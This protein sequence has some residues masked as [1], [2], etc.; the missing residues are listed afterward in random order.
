MKERYRIYQR[1]GG[2][3]Y[4]K[5]RKTGQ[6]VSL[7]T[8]DFAEAKRLLAAKNQAT[9]QPCLNVA[10]AK[11]YLSAQSPEF[12]SR[13]WGQLIELV[14]Q[15][16]EGATANRWRKFAK[17]APLKILI[18]LPIYQSEA[19][20]FLA[21]LDHK[22]A[23]VSTNVWLRILH[24]RALDLGWLLSPVLKKRLWPKV[25]YKARRGITAE[26][27]AKVL[28]SENLEDYRQFFRLLWETGGSQTD[29]VNLTGDNV[30]W[31]KER[32]FY[33]RQKLASRGSGRAA[34]ANCPVFRHGRSSEHTNTQDTSCR[35][36][37]VSAMKIRT[38]EQMSF[39]IDEDLAWRKRELSLFLATIDGARGTALTGLARAGI[40]LL[41]AHWEGFTK[42]ASGVFVE[43]VSAT[44]P[45][46]G[47]LKPGLATLCWKR[48]AN[49][50]SLPGSLRELGRVST[51]FLEQQG[52]RMPW[53]TADVIDTKSNLNYELACDILW[54]LSLDSSWLEPKS[55]L[56]DRK[57]LGR[58]NH[59]AHGQWIEVD[60]DEYR[61]LHDEVI[62]IL[63]EISS[64]IQNCALQEEYLKAIPT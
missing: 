1:S 45:P 33:S 50:G 54:A 35:P 17:S 43:F 55:L 49:W 13:T 6:R 61:Y 60:L 53:L 64:R 22:Q 19:V 11:V 18:N 16:Y 46:L 57:L 40:A 4:A 51:L 9:E 7:A 63:S 5:D 24:N 26:E 56:L 62:A 10:M 37:K 44:R 31:Q 32:L 41:Y 38:K 14:A 20:H 3:F 36:S 48:Y 30:D 47:T 2:M 39:E 28:A 8:S 42:K 27:H 21:V 12:L 58:R 52:A 25:Q 29:I 15:G 23:G 59:I 34:L